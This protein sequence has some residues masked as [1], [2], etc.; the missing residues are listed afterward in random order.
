MSTGKSSLYF[1]PAGMRT[2]K[3][4]LWYDKCIHLSLLQK[5]WVETNHKTKIFFTIKISM[6]S[7][8]NSHDFTLI[9]KIHQKVYYHVNFKK[10]TIMLTSKINVWK[11]HSKGSSLTILKY[12]WCM[13]KLIISSQLTKIKKF[14]LTIFLTFPQNA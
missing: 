1:F 13:N 8:V 10:Y 11:L 5:R 7:K 4:F 14:V 12:E 2:I 9:L 3:F 6:T